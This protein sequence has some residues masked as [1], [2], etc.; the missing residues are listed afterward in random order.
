MRL[1][2]KKIILLTTMSMMG[3]GLLTI[4]LD[5]HSTMA[6]QGECDASVIGSQ[7]ADNVNDKV[8]ILFNDSKKDTN[9]VLATA[10]PTPTSTPTPSPIPSP[11]HKITE[12]KNAEMVQLFKDYYTAKAARGIK[13]LKSLLS[14]PAKVESKAALKDKT[15]FIVDY[16]NVRVYAKNGLK[17]GTYIVYVYTEIKIFNIKTSAPSLAKFLVVTGDD[18]KLK[19]FSGEMNEEVSE[20]YDNRQ[21]DK[22][23]KYLI[24]VTNTKSK[25]AKAKDKNLKEFWDNIDALAKSAQTVKSE[26]ADKDTTNKS[27][28]KASD[29]KSKSA[30]TASKAT[31]KTDIAP[32][33]STKSKDTVSGINTNSKKTKT[34]KSN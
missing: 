33:K 29:K 27:I 22:D 11:L 3:I 4:S 28:A 9:E 23:V 31:K 2:Y 7:L 12:K 25:K 16:D 1:K 15:E 26:D 24:E 20:Y 13:K 5:Q 17:E 19:I 14:D 10:T 32:N 18:G 30:E 34:P 8:G 6:K 21:N